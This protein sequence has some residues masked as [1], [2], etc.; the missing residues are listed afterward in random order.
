M[1]M[2]KRDWIL[3]DDYVYCNGYCNYYFFLLFFIM[4]AMKDPGDWVT[5]YTESVADILLKKSE[6][7]IADEPIPKDDNIRRRLNAI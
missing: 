3:Y 7:I 6:P 1:M 4:W 5:Y 2:Q